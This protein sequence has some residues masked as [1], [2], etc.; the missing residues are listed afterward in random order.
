MEDSAANRLVT[1]NIDEFR[2]YI[3]RIMHHTAQKCYE[4]LV[5][6]G[7][8]EAA[9]LLAVGNITI[10]GTHQEERTRLEIN[11]SFERAQ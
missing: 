1:M 2:E 6:C 4:R 3:V 10:E 5:T 8:D 7:Y 11:I 9:D